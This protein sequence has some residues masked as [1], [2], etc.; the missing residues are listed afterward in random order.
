MER[1]TK[2]VVLLL[3]VTLLCASLLYYATDEYL[4]NQSIQTPTSKE[5]PVELTGVVFDIQEY[6]EG[7]WRSIVYLSKGKVGNSTWYNFTDHLVTEGEFGLFRLSAS[8]PFPIMVSFYSY[9]SKDPKFSLIFSSL[10]GNTCVGSAHG[11]IGDRCFN[12]DKLKDVP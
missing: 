2:F 11:S 9:P 6:K 3:V 4:K 7:V 5:T 10:G 12:T 1:Q 8:V